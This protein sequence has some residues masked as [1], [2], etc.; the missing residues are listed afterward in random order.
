MQ[1]SWSFY[2][3]LSWDI[4]LEE[5]HTDPMTG[6]GNLFACLNDLHERFGDAPCPSASYLMLADIDDLSRVNDTSGRSAGD[7]ALML[8]RATLLD[9]IDGGESLFRF[10]RDTF[11]LIGR[12]DRT[13]AENL[14]HLVRRTYRERS[15]DVFGEDHAP[16]LSVG[17]AVTEDALCSVGEIISAANQAL[18]TAKRQG[19]D[20]V[21]ITEAATRTPGEREDPQ[22]ELLTVF[23]GQ[24]LETLN[25]LADVGE[26][27]LTDP[28][29][30]LP[31]QRA[32][33]S[34]LAKAVVEAE[35]RSTPLSTLL[36][37][38]D[39]LRE[40]NNRFGYN[41]GNQMILD[42]TDILSESKRTTDFLARWF[43][44]DE[45]LLVLPDTDSRQALQVAERIRRCVQEEASTWEIPIT[46]SIGTATYPQ[47]ATKPSELISLAQDACSEAKR[48]GKNCVVQSRDA[49]GCEHR[50]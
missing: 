26:M 8:A 14:G 13:G 9:A 42:L 37:D 6:L 28:L 7:R 40:Y 23:S 34:Y 48:R 5:L 25:V 31:N 49:A 33:A 29:T 3:G 21:V 16:T 11:A 30:G 43:L 45:F 24:I 44:G 18:Y 20:T 22:A 2:P 39:R 27:A 38:G 4:D 10:S 19:G 47:D 46:I 36:V 41:R 17:V 1:T 50:G 32:G 12:L 35:A 15:V